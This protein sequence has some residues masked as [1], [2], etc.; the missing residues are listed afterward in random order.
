MSGAKTRIRRKKGSFKRSLLLGLIFGIFMVVCQELAYQYRVQKQYKEPGHV[1]T[2]VPKSTESPAFETPAAVRPEISPEQGAD[3]E[4]SGIPVGYYYSAGSN[5]VTIDIGTEEI[6]IDFV[7]LTSENSDFTGWFVIPG[8]DI[9]YPVVQGADNAFYLNHIFNGAYGTVGTLFADCNNVMLED[10]NTI[11]YG[12]NFHQYGTMF[13]KLLYYEKQD[14][15]EEHPA[16][17]YLTEEGG[18]KIEIFSVYEASTSDPI[19]TLS[20]AGDEEYKVFLDHVAEMSTIRS[21][22]HV[23]VQDKVITLSTCSNR[24]SDGR[25]VVVGKIVAFA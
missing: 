4:G 25:F 14:Y 11:I 24:Y 20:F 1:V 17:Y 23:T 15:Y 13:S 9:S 16:M 2:S 19:Y 18:Y 5:D 6:T 21:D 22:T 10:E 7:A 12:H 3:V 8:T